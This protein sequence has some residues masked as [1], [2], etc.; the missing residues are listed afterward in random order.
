MATT[1]NSTPEEKELVF[2]MDANSRTVVY[3]YCDDPY[4]TKRLNKIGATKLST[5]F[6]NH[7]Q[8]NVSDFTKL[9]GLQKALKL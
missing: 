3:V 6:G 5:N 2:N 9:F 1:T 8:I 4:W 7:Y